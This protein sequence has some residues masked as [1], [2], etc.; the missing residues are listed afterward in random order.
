M[1]T[2]SFVPLVSYCMQSSHGVQA[3]GESVLGMPRSAHHFTIPG[4]G[5]RRH[6][7]RRS[8]RR[9]QW[10]HEHE[11]TR[12]DMYAIIGHELPYGVGSVV[13]KI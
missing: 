2:V 7:R 8:G 1:K 4:L 11:S 13:D 10:L 5:F 3:I 9:C 12:G 6:V